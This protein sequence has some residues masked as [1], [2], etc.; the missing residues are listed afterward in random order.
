MNQDQSTQFEVL[1]AAL[2]EIGALDSSA[3]LHIKQIAWK[4][5]GEIDV[6][7]DRLRNTNETG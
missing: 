1:V 4:A 3:P 5:L 7:R 2:K 6:D